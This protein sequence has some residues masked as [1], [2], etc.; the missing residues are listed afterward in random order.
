LN[1]AYNVFSSML[2][3]KLSSYA[4]NILEDYQCG[5]RPGRSTIDQIFTVRQIMEEFYENKTDIYMLFIDFRQ[6]FDSIKWKQLIR[7]LEKNLTSPKN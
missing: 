2:Q 1:V 4:E 5:F 7:T 3:R 6:A